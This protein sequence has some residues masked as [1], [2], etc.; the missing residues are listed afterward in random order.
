M[1]NNLFS[2]CATNYSGLSNLVGTRV[3]NHR[4]MTCVI[5]KLFMTEQRFNLLHI[6]VRRGGLRILP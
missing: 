5:V 2:V 1:A 4:S 3:R 6:V